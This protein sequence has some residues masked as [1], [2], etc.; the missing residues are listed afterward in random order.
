MNILSRLRRHAR[1]FLHA[2][3][4]PS[5]LVM[6]AFAAAGCQSDDSTSPITKVPDASTDHT[7]SAS[8]A[9]SEAGKAD[10]EA[11]E[12]AAATDSGA[13]DAQ[14]SETDAQGE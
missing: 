1:L 4:W 12:A 13:T 7:S 9:G 14:T 6:C 5:A 3:V 10:A 11:P 8:E 2:A